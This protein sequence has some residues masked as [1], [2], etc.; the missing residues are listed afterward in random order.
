[1]KN[2]FILVAI[3]I[4]LAGCSEELPEEYDRV[5]ISTLLN[6]TWRTECI[7]DGENSYLPT[8]TFT[9][10]GGKDYDSGTGTS[11]NIYHT[12][13]T[14]CATFDPEI[15]DINTFSYSIGEIVIID[16][17]VDELT[18]AIEIDTVNTTE[19]SADIGAEEYDIFAIKDKFTLYFGDKTDP[20]NGTTAELRPTQLTDTVVYIR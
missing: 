8:L 2:T 18:E 16:G 1:M 9:S 10:N 11:S 6:A 15:Q 7:I 19:D 12:G 20:I 13:D 4:S 14:T 3:L 17:S 5:V